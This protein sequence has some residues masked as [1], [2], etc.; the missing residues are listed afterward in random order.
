MPFCKLAE[1]IVATLPRDP[2]RHRGFPEAASV[3]A[4][5]SQAVQGGGGASM[6]SIITVMAVMIS[7]AASAQEQPLPQLQSR[8]RVVA[9]PA[10]GKSVADFSSRHASLW[11]LTQRVSRG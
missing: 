8:P 2:E 3:C 4:L 6:R 7:V 1:E 9:Q 11:F 10:D 5:R